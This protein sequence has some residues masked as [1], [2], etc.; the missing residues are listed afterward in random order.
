MSEA[1]FNFLPLNL[2]YLRDHKMCGHGASSTSD[3]RWSRR[4]R[5]SRSPSPRRSPRYERSFCR[6]IC[7][8]SLR[9]IRKPP[10]ASGCFR[11]PS[12]RASR[13]IPTRS[14]ANSKRSSSGHSSRRCASTACAIP[15]RG[16]V[17]TENQRQTHIQERICQDARG[18]RGKAGRADKDDESGNCRDEKGS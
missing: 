18:M 17:H 10:P 11:R 14:T 3:V 2:G 5:R 16:A 12:R 1:I 13:G 8:I 7:W 6:P 9:C 4:G 15:L